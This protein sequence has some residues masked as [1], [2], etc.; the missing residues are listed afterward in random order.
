MHVRCLLSAQA[1]ERLDCRGGGG[2]RSLALSAA[3]KGGQS[4]EGFGLQV[5]DTLDGRNIHMRVLIFQLSTAG[6]VA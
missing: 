5:R 4:Q 2:W 6:Q 1:A 3:L